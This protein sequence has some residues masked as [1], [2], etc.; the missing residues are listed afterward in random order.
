MSNGEKTDRDR[1]KP[2]NRLLTIQ[3]KLM[4]IRTEVGRGMG[5]RGDGD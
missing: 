4:V 5:E 3:N 1:D 2:R